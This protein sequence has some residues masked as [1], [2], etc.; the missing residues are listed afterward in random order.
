MGRSAF[1]DASGWERPAL[2]SQGEGMAELRS[3]VRT[4]LITGIPLS[5]VGTLLIDA[6]ND[7]AEVMIV[8]VEEGMELFAFMQLGASVAERYG[9]EAKPA[10]A[11]LRFGI[12]PASLAFLIRRHSRA[13]RLV[14]LF[15]ESRD[16]A[17]G[18][19]EHENLYIPR[20]ADWDLPEGLVVPGTIYVNHESEKPARWP[21]RLIA[22]NGLHA[23]PSDRELPELI[24]KKGWWRSTP[25]L[26]FRSGRW[27]P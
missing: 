26:R 16:L 19:L 9:C 15:S 5:G 13:C 27:C 8:L 6:G 14:K 7:P 25:P 12:H 24:M 17:V 11:C 2:A 10:M 3:M 23:V 22:L 20:K 18:I 4:L 21:E 1:L